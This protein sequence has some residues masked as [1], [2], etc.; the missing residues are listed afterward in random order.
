MTQ[1]KYALERVRASL[2][3]LLALAQGGTAVGTGLNAKP[4][5]LKH[6]PPRSRDSPV[7]NS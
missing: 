2:P 4:D 5:L 7:W 3:R 1:L 6:L